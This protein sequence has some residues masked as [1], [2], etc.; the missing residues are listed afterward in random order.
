[1]Y[2]TA[3]VKSKKSSHW[4]TKFDRSKY[5]ILVGNIKLYFKTINCSN[6][7]TRYKRCQPTNFEFLKQNSPFYKKLNAH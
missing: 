2:E 5:F 3:E 7:T 1:M 4:Y 6:K